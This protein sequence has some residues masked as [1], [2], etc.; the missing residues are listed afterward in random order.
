MDRAESIV[1]QI[2]EAKGAV[3]KARERNPNASSKSIGGLIDYITNKWG[4]MEV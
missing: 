4:G 2:D 1:R 3:R